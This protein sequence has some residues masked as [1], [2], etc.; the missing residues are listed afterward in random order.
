MSVCLCITESYCCTPEI[1]TTLLIN[2]T[3]IHIFNEKKNKTKDRK[4][5][6]SS[7]PLYIK[8]KAKK[9]KEKQFKQQWISQ[10]KTWQPEGNEIIFFKC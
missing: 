1:N 8:G 10:Q 5:H 4:N 3:P 6:E 2:Y 7:Q 9:K